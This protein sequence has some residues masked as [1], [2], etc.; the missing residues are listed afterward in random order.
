MQKRKKNEYRNEGEEELP[1]AEEAVALVLLLLLEAV[2]VLVLLE[3]E[4]VDSRTAAVALLLVA[5]REVLPPPLSSVSFPFRFLPFLLLLWFSFPP[6]S[7][8]LVLYFPLPFLSLSVFSF[9]S[10]LLCFSRFPP[11][12][13]SVIGSIYRAKGRGFLWLHM[14]SKGCG[15]WSAIWVQLS[16]YGFPV[17]SGRRAAGGRPVG[18]AG[19]ER[20]PRFSGKACGP[21]GGSTLAEEKPTIFLSSPAARPG[22]EERGTVSFKTTPF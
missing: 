13:L 21:E 7:F 18:V 3:A 10:T 12:P 8:L 9:S 20:L 2:P 1:G 15:G 17:F 22:E 11:L 14:G 6:F 19:E 4:A 16:R 5:E